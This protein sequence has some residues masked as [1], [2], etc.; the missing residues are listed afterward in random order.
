MADPNRQGLDMDYPITKGN[1][2]YFQQTFDTFDSER[3]KLINLM[4]TLE[5]ER[6]MQPKFGLGIEKYLFE[7]ITS[8]LQSRLQ[9]EIRSKVGFWLPNIQI[10]DMT[11]D[12]V[13]GVDRN[14]VTIKI[15]FS[16]KANPS[17]F[18]VVTFTF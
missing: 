16:L 9:S 18:D 17:E 7:Q 1:M 6:V 15:D 5:G 13:S 4:S 10:N 3:N 8:D 12:I 11:V 14:I 2:G